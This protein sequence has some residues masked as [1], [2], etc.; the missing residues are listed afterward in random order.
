M[1]HLMTW[2][3]SKGWR[4]FNLVGAI[5]SCF[6]W[7]FATWNGWIDSVQFVSH[8]SMLALVVSFIAAWRADVPIVEEEK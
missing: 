3:G 5:V 4:G 7:A 2:Q 6:L 8:V 1:R